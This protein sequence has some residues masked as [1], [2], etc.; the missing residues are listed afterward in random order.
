MHATR[1]FSCW[2]DH[3]HVNSVEAI[4][5]FVAPAILAMMALMA[6]MVGAGPGLLAF[7]VWAFLVVRAVYCVVYLRGGAP[8][9]GGNL[10]AILHVLGSLTASVLIVAVAVAALLRLDAL[11][12]EVDNRTKAKKTGRDTALAAE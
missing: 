8:A 2:L 7:L 5:S 10:R 12:N 4:P 6:L 9:K 1:T 11:N 3:T